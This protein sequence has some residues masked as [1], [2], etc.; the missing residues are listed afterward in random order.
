VFATAFN[1]RRKMFFASF[2]VIMLLGVVS[3]LIQFSLISIF[4]SIG[5]EMELYTMSIGTTG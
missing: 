1:M 2:D 3:T 5:N 4:L